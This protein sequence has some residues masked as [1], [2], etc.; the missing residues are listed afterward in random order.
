[1]KQ[2]EQTYVIEAPLDKVWQAFVEPEIIVRWGGGPA[3][4]SAEA[5]SDFSLWGGDIFGTNTKVVEHELLEQD[6]YSGDQ[7]PQPSKV[8]FSFK[9]DGDKTIVRLKHTN[10]PDDE[11]KDIEQGWQDYYLGPIKELLES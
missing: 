6:W 10:I 7:W 1:M 3:K 11:A 2:V 8:T 4:M 9:S 5:S